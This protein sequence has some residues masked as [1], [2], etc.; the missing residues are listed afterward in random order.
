MAASLVSTT[1]G[2]AHAVPRTGADTAP[3]QSG[4]PDLQTR[5]DA[6]KD[7][8]SFRRDT[9]ILA[10]IMHAGGP[11]MK[12][13]AGA[14]LADGDYG[15][16]PTRELL[17]GSESADNVR[18][19]T[20]GS[21][22]P[23]RSAG[24]DQG[25]DPVVQ[26]A[27]ATLPNGHL[28]VGM[29]TR[30][31]KLYDQVRFPNG[32][33][34][35][36]MLIN[37]DAHNVGFAEATLPNG[38]LHFALLSD[39]G[40]VRDFSF[41]PGD[42]PSAYMFGML[43][44][45][46]TADWL[47]GALPGKVK[48]I[49]LAGLPNNDLHL[50]LLTADGKLFTG[51]RHSGKWADP[52]PADS[53]TVP[54]T[55]VSALATADGEVRLE[56]LG[57]DHKVRERVRKTDGTHTAATLVDDSGT[58]RALS[59]TAV[60]GALPHVATLTADGTVADFAL[61]TDGGWTR[62]AAPAPHATALSLGALKTGELQLDVSADDGRLWTTGRT[63]D[64]GWSRPYVVDGAFGRTKDIQLAAAA[65]GDLDVLSLADDGTVWL[66]VN[67]K[68]ENSWQNKVSGNTQVD[69]S[70]HARAIAVASAADGDVHALVLADDNTVRDTVGH[71]D[72]SWDAPVAV[73]TS[74]TAR[75]VTAVGTPNGEVHLG[76]L[77]A[78]GSVQDT[79]RAADGSWAAPRA[80]TAPHAKGLA[81]AA[82]PNGEAH[83]VV[84]ADDG[85]V[86]D[87]LRHADGNW[88]GA[89]LV[90][91][92]TESRQVAAAGAPDNTLHLIELRTDGSARGDYRKPDGGWVLSGK[93]YGYIDPRTTSVS[94]AV[95]GDGN[96][97]VNQ[98]MAP[99]DPN[100][101]QTDA[102]AAEAADNT[103]SLRDRGLGRVA[104]GY[105]TTGGTEQKPAYDTDIT[106]YM[107][108]NGVRAR[109][110]VVLQ[111]LPAPPK[112]AQPAL[113]KV[114]AVVA[115]LIAAN[116]GNDP[117]GIYM[118]LGAQT[119]NG[120]A[121]DVRRFI[122]YHGTPTVAPAKGTPEFR[123]EVEA[124][125]AR[126]ASGDVTN[127]QD[128]QNVLVEAEET[129]S[130][131]WVAEQAAQAGP[132]ATLLTA[133]TR[134]LAALQSGTE[135]MHQALGYGWAAGRILRWQANPDK[136]A[137]QS[138]PH[139][140]AQ[141][142]ADL[143][144]IKELVAA[145]AAIA[146]KAADDAK[147]AA[148]QVAPATA[149]GDRIAD[150]AGVP[151]GR[152]MTY[153][154][155]SGQVT[156]ASAAAALATAN[157][158][159]TAVA[160][161][162]A[163]AADSATLLANAEAQ[164]AAARA[165]FQ[166]Q[167]AQD[168]A[169]RAAELAAAAE[170]GA[171]A[172][173][174]AA[175]N[176]ATAKT[177]AVQAQ[178]DATAANDR[179][180]TAADSAAAERKN[181]ADAKTDADTQRA[182]ARTALSD[183]LE[184][185][186]TSS[187]KRAAAQ[188]ASSDATAKL[189]AAKDAA[190]R[191]AVARTTAV[192]AQQQKDAAQAQAQALAAAA[193][194]AQGTDAAADAQDRAT[195]AAAAAAQAAT[196]ADQAAAQA[197]TA[198][199]AAVGARKAATESAAAS[200]RATAWSAD[201]DA[202]ALLA[203]S[204]AT[205]AEANAATAI[206]KAQTAAGNATKAAGDAEQ[207]AQAAMTAA[208]KVVAAV[209]AV[210]QAVDAAATAAGQAYAAGRAA[211]AARA[212]A[213][214]VTAPADQAIA[215]GAPF[216]VTDSSAGLA[217]LAS[218]GALTLAQQQ[219]AA[220]DAAAAQA[221]QAA[222]DARA[223]AQAATGDG[224]LA[225]Q[226]AAEAAD[227]AARAAGSADT[228]QKSA[229]QAAADATAAKAAATAAAAS[230]AQARASAQ[231]AS[232]A[233]TAAA[234]DSQAA[235]AAATA[236]EKDATAAAATAATADADAK[237]ARSA[238]DQAATKATAAEQSATT[239]QADATAAEQ[240]ATTAQE[241]L[242]RD[243]AALAA[244][245][246]AARAAA[247]SQH[248]LDARV[249]AMQQ[250]AAV[251]VGRANLAYLLRVGGVA[252]KTLA[253][254][255][256]AGPGQPNPSLFM[257]QGVWDAWSA[258]VKTAQDAAT[259]M[260]SRTSARQNTVWKYFTYDYSNSEPVYD[261]AVTKQLDPGYVHERIG[262][263][264]GY[265]GNAD[266]PQASPAAQERVAQILKEKIA[267][268]DPYGWWKIL[269]DNPQ[270]RGS[271]D[272]IRRFIQYDGYP[273]VAPA[274]GTAEFRLE[275]ESLK[276]RWA[277]G[278]PTNPWDPNQVMVEV[279]ED[280]SAEWEAEYA[281]QAQQRTDIANA[282]VKALT[283]LQSS[284][285]AMH[286]ALGN[287]WVAKNL[288][289]AQADP[290]SSWN[291]FIKDWPTTMGGNFSPDGGPIS[292]TDDLAA[293]KKAVDDLS[294]T[295]TANAADAAAADT[296][297]SAA[298]ASA[299]RVAAGGGLPA[300]RGLSYA[301]ESAQVVKAAA[302]ATQATSLAMRTAVAAT[303]ATVADSGALLANAS[304]QAHAARA[305]FLR[306]TAQDDA[307]KAAADAVAAQ[308]KADA[309]AAAAAIAAHDKA[310]IV[311]LE[312][313]SKD[314][315]AR[316]HQ[317]AVTAEQERANAASARQTAETQRGVAAAAN[318]D[319]Q[320]KKDAATASEAAA[321]GEADRAAE[322]DRTA[323]LAE[324]NAA[325]ARS[326]AEDARK[327]SDAARAKSAAADAAAAAA[328]GTGAA[329]DAEAAAKAAKLDAKAAGL[330]ADQ[331]NTD[332]NNARDAATA[333]RAA[334]TVSTAA[335]A[336]S[337]AAAKVADAAA[338]TSS[339]NAA[340]GDAL[341][342]EAIEQ[343]G[344]A[345]RNAEA[346]DTL[347]KQAAQEAA[348]AKAAAD[349][350]KQEADG[351]VSDAAT[352]SG[353][354]YAASQQAEIARDTANAVAAPADQAIELGISFAAT[355]ATAGLSVAVADTSKTL[356]EQ[357]AAVA[358][359]RASEA[360]AFA[361]AAK[362]AA[363]R[364][365]GDAKLAAQ[366][367]A[368]AAASA[369]AA[370]RSAADALKSAARAA[371]DAKD[372][373]AVSER[374]DAINAQTQYEAWNADR[375]AA[376]A[377]QEAEAADA[378]ATAG[379]KD[380][381]A[382]RE[383]ATAARYAADSAGVWASDA[384]SSADSAKEAAGSAQADADETAKIEEGLS[385]LAQDPPTATAPAADPDIP[386]LVVEPVDLKQEGQATGNCD[387]GATLGHCNLPV[388]IHIT[389]TNMLYLV[390]CQLPNA[391]AGQCIQTGQYEKDF[392]TSLPI[393][394]RT[395]Q[396]LDINVWE[397]DLNFVK[398]FGYSLVSDYVNCYKHFDLTSRDC[399]WA[400]G[401]LVVPAALKAVFKSVYTMRAALAINDMVGAEAA[402]NVLT[403][404][405]KAAVISAV[406]LKRLRQAFALSRLRNLLKDCFTPKHSFQAGTPVLMADGSTKPIEQVRTGDVVAAAAPGGAPERHRVEKTFVTSSDTE[407][408]DLTV[409][410]PDGPRTVTGT[411]NHP[412]LDLTRDDFVDAARL[413]VGDRLQSA[414]GTTVTVLGVRNH[415]SAMVTYDLTV[416]ALHTYYVVAGDVPV[417]VHNICDAEHLVLGIKEYSNPLAV[418]LR[419]AGAEGAY[420]L[421]DSVYG[422]IQPSGRPKWMEEVSRVAVDPNIRLS[423]TLDGLPGETA[424]EAFQNA[425]IR[426]VK[427]GDAG[428]ANG[429]FG[430]A[431]EMSVIGRSVFLH[432]DDA[433]YGRPWSSIQFFWKNR[434]VTVQEPDWAV[435]RGL[436]GQ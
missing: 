335:A 7:A 4:Q 366:A 427:A 134:A 143:A 306:A 24:L 278:D 381:G 234:A 88:D 433:S 105:A 125:K 166:R 45:F 293:V 79:V 191:A 405:A 41:Q 244:Q 217:N 53:G 119:K 272:D 108:A 70:G 44:T 154:V 312:D 243:E 202:N 340:Q 374:L 5:L 158:L 221:A 205:A 199:D 384:Q 300:G 354:A 178:A 99:A 393:D 195:A 423:V 214:A 419:D 307:Q 131:E 266:V 98:L 11:A 8:E 16:W 346:A 377:K 323:R 410:T 153:A 101:G 314:A 230:D 294:A 197:Q 229:A 412:Y 83:L 136:R 317:A 147:A 280:A 418:D 68:A 25:V 20:D 185:S 390:T 169:A 152:G 324:Q 281:A 65:N 155:Q 273:T 353:Q 416:E 382:A 2:A 286:D 184:K 148:D 417:L 396:V 236:G 43:A 344:V 302:A 240:S 84:L 288:M 316:A 343:A 78:D 364:A 34:S 174:A 246:A 413:G 39:D 126:W 135:A 333:S 378:A 279:E 400:I 151:R 69:G 187:A 120:S 38:E 56:L 73:D 218:Q 241:Q 309:A 347:A 431:W 190:D 194:A 168:S 207:A 320:A 249:L 376:S 337:S 274:K 173:A 408:T 110:N 268:G 371:S 289:D 426:G 339:A 387:I 49:A 265:G 231:S 95:Q 3:S 198:T 160:A 267:A 137:Y 363:D 12:S 375:S 334:A 58:A 67:R 291:G 35:G 55:A 201:A 325:A 183:A 52:V 425:Y 361:A 57:A 1:I 10:N 71:P 404:T 277:S 322:D 117:Y 103:R 48:G 114:D 386:G 330:A 32:D 392:I 397:F 414:D 89:V 193:V 260:Y 373:K 22:E 388:D 33:W 259:G 224:K 276:T 305:A 282:E 257:D 181:A 401:S 92:Q 118:L 46:N 319:A 140:D 156:R 82:T 159:D 398:S 27:Q 365:T 211:D 432:A 212:A 13:A 196:A 256:L 290:N 391:P 142:G 264:A 251:R 248:D 296:A 104:D 327:A 26:S 394:V 60:P 372:V 179:A 180:K 436:A 30:D 116:G 129:A 233:A 313:S 157:A 253:A 315:Q 357:E 239:A 341:A 415:T 435:L 263:V 321:K 59:A 406:T 176:V 261:T 368:D 177:Q 130:A 77:R 54:S 161:I 420:T 76:T 255:R 308:D 94:T 90:D 188:S 247:Q 326:R 379:E 170:A 380:A 220:A 350:A 208:A 275:V 29:L 284:A 359:F 186:K 342:A 237:S 203:Y 132:R 144:T 112:A 311:P 91:G 200:A 258:D 206:A 14:V 429:S 150:A 21:A 287:A 146:H 358:D 192:V 338:A 301:V 430:T 204:A 303:N 9:A 383:A 352:A 295:A 124:L 336:K 238:A 403:Q 362:D 434:P 113:A 254:V 332:A 328:A 235:A 270:L 360:A 80:L 271:A 331:A 36:P 172:A 15:P 351:A 19:A 227:S 133:E 121:D 138:V 106:D 6:L 428:G 74:G 28:H 97:H 85:K 245:A 299:G 127:P 298:V 283:A 228:A 225:A 367:A 232:A 50:E 223:A 18:P 86:W 141:A 297:A 213:A 163:T 262:R 310:V 75:A 37:G 17:L 399:V 149:E 66:R 355:D 81:A 269:L 123:V 164:A 242:R 96:L 348:D 285:V 385:R 87:A 128:W 61:R 93:Q 318:A 292:L 115:E 424:E 389:G 329:Q 23:T 62:T 171:D 145:Q 250:Q 109:D 182:G 64:G 165:Q 139:T 162:D 210:D 216:A 63:A 409:S 402:L 100:P 209:Q 370:S 356:A 252:S 421:N 72:G 422:D 31:G 122:Q 222:A 42:Y 175:A 345:Q 226:A 111:Q 107:S 369:A 40:T 304:A 167:S 51:V 411:Q 349:G 189:A 215:L 219:V 395:H 102:R 407:F 47:F